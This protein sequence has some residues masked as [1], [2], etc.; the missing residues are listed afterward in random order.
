VLKL[1]IEDG[2]YTVELQLL[3]QTDFPFQTRL[4]LSES[5]CELQGNDLPFLAITHLENGR[6]SAP[7]QTTQILIPFI[8]DI[9]N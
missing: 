3:E 4:K 5:R 6:E 9:A 2:D 7:P 1:E 8:E